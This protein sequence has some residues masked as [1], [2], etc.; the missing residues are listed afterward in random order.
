M[1][2]SQER[3]IHRAVVL[4]GDEDLREG[5]EYA[6]GRGV[7]VAVVGVDPN[8]DRSQSV[9]LPRR[10]CVLRENVGDEKQLQAAS[11]R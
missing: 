4:S 7:R 9:L 3:S 5:A 1:V 11:L 8:G 2:L 10:I 6:Q